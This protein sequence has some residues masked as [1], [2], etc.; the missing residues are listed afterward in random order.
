MRNNRN[1]RIDAGRLIALIE[2]YSVRPI[3]KLDER[4]FRFE[5]QEAEV[6]FLNETDRYIE[7]YGVRLTERQRR[8]L[9]R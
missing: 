6:N 9:Q 1:L 3:H 4:R 8:Q 7:L 2:L 5:N